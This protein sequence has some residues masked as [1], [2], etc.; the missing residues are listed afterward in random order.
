M[1]KK[2]FSSIVVSFIF[3]LQIFSSFTPIGSAKADET[4]FPFVT[5]VT[6]TDGSGNDI[7]QETN[8]DKDSDV[9]VNYDFSI[10]EGQT[11][12]KETSYTIQLPDQIKLKDIQ[13]DTSVKDSAGTLIGSFTADTASNK[14]SITFSNDVTGALSGK[15]S[16]SAQFDGSKI[17]NTNPVSINLGKNSVNVN[18]R[19]DA[20]AGTSQSSGTTPASEVQATEASEPNDITNSFPFITGVDIKKDNIGSGTALG[21]DVA[22]DSEI[23]IKYTWSIPN[24]VAVN[25]GNYYKMQLPEEI[26]IAAPINQEITDDSGEKIADMNI[27]TGGLVTLTFT[28]YPNTHSD[29]H[30]YFYV[31]CHFEPSKIGN[32]NPVTINF[33]VPG[34]AVV[35]VNVN[36]EQPVDASVTKSGSYDKA[37]DEITWTII[38]NKE[39]IQANDATITDTISDDGQVFVPGSITINGTSVDDTYYD[40]ST[41]A[42][43]F[44][45]GNIDTKQTITY[46]TSVKDFLAAKLQGTYNFN[47][48][49]DFSYND[50]KSAPHTE[51]VNASAVSATVTYISKTG[52]YDPANKKINWTITVNE[53]AKT[54]NNAVV[55]DVIPGGLTVDTSSI[56]VKDEYG[57][58]L[59]SPDY[60]GNITFNLG[61][62]T[63]KR[64]ITYSTSVD[65]TV[66][67]SNNSKTY[68][69]NA[70]FTGNGSTLGTSGD[71]VGV[72]PN[73]IA[74]EGIGYDPSTGIITWKI[75]V[76]SNKTNVAAGATVTDTIPVGQTYVPGS[77][78]LDGTSIGDGGYTAA[79]SGDST[80]TGIFVYIF[81]SSFSDT[82]TIIF[83]TQVT[84][85]THYRANY[86][87]SYSN[88]VNLTAENINQSTPGSQNVDSEIISKTS[89]GYDY[90]TREITWK[91][92][93][94]NNKMPI[95][96]AVVTDVI[97]AGQQYATNSASIDDVANGSFTTLSDNQ[98]VY[99]FTGTINK[100]YTIIFKTKLTDLSI[101]NTNGD[102]TVSN[103]ASITGDEIPVD[104]DN[105]ASATQIIHN[106]V[107][108][109][110]AAYTNGNSYID[111]TVKTNSNSNIAMGGA[112]IT[113]Y[114]QK[115][116]SLDISSVRLYKMDVNPSTGELTPRDTTETISPSNIS[117]DSATGKFVFTFP[118]G[119]SGP[120]MLKFST[121]IDPII[122]NTTVNNSVQFVGTEVDQ[123]AD[124]AGVGVWVSNGG[125]GGSGQTGSIKVVKVSDDGITPL[126]GAVFE[127]LDWTGSV[128]A[129]SATTGTDGIALFDKLK[130][131]IDYTIKEKT[132]PTGY[133]LSSEPYTFQ[134]HNAADQKDITY[135]FTD[136]RKTGNVTFTKTGEDSDSAALSGA[137]FTLYRPDGDGITPVTDG[138]GNNITATS[139]SDG[140][141]TFTNVPFG[142][143]IIETKAP[144]GYSINSSPLT[145]TV[146]DGGNVVLDASSITDTKIRSDVQFT[147]EDL[148]GN[149]LKGAE[150]KLYKNDDINFQNPIQTATSD[151]NGIVKFTGVAYG[152]K[153]KETI[154]P[155]GYYLS[156]EVLTAVMS[157]DGNSVQLDKND[158]ADTRITGGGGSIQGTVSVK[159]TDDS[160]NALSGAVFTLYNSSGNSVQTATSD[161][162][163]AA[164]FTKVQPG[165]YTVKETVAPAGY[166]LSTQ[167]IPVEIN[168]SKTYDIGTIKDTKNAAAIEVKKTDAN[169]NALSGAEFTLYNSG[170]KVASAVSGQDGI[171]R[172]S[173]VVYGNYTV[174]ETR[175]PAGYDLNQDTLSVQVD[176]SKTYQFTVA[177]EKGTPGSNNP[178]GTPNPNN[179]GGGTPD[180]SNPGGG[181]PNPNNPG[182][183]S[184]DLSN[185]QGGTPSSIS[186]SLPKTGSMVDTTVLLVVGIMAILAGIWMMKR[187]KRSEKNI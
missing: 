119:F 140:K 98:V 87:G 4:A 175:A 78:K 130:Y 46:R 129:T 75:T 143:K 43:T 151:E 7:S 179:P 113:D 99:T 8:V 147:K 127:L 59:T 39:N 172:F 22:K 185:P 167:V 81:S 103:S 21:D 154:P 32:S 80:K 52:S 181:T 67:N 160:G 126:P 187:S 27:T 158:V 131:D 133:N 24:T 153:I 178:G 128:K 138:S 120:F 157:Q 64:T 5:G 49:A 6:L 68:T 56:S 123:S 33:T 148:S 116:L 51:T 88:S 146:D 107:I 152:Y 73:I 23:F 14:A 145:A 115:G 91:I 82:H 109:K 50:Y 45:P 1:K 156:N 41:K 173:N 13:T 35:P 100:T 149:P 111:W 164:Q 180:S 48:T 15:F 110:E 34:I 144:T 125:G 168:M 161:A 44:G 155:T 122:N 66:Y 150:F 65:P 165:K 84:D 69:N 47:N 29:V 169:G 53:D 182:G 28:D 97:P 42:L 174:K 61:N 2:K 58:P 37:T 86:N 25:P 11:A 40:S 55:T 139:G 20:P 132:A 94:N 112:T 163:G 170:V 63:G 136:T 142:Y 60:S 17:G 118:D 90:S 74:K 166:V 77:A 16:V 36:F 121:D 177:D 102:K 184:P 141:V 9:N 89:G 106:T 135:N 137:E 70:T 62:I 10:P 18:F 83:Q 38:A 134:I 108:S 79:D 57:T 186:Q 105:D 95:T 19:Q 104:G 92:V 96:N 3:L 162:S 12:V 31:D 93:V 159:K 54:I 124:S 183:G 176:S 171:A 30:G 117:Y 76:N 85:P 71:G 26:H 114:L 72:N 101:F